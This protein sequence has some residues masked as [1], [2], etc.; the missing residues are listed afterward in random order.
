MKNN[1]GTV[2][3]TGTSPPIMIT[4]DH[5][6]SKQRI[7]RKRSREEQEPG[8][9]LRLDTPASSRR[10]SI[11][12]SDDNRP[13]ALTTPTLLDDDIPLDNAVSNTQLQNA[14]FL[15]NA[16]FDLDTTNN[17]EMEAWPYNRRRRTIQGYTST[18]ITIDSLFD[19]FP[20]TPSTPI[21]QL[22]RL[23]PA[24]GPTYGGIEVTLL[25]S[26]FYD[27]LTCLFG[28]HAV[29]TVFWNTSTL[30]CILPPAAQ[31]GPVVVSF[32]EHPLVLGQ[33]DVAIFT[34]LDTSD[35]AL[36]EL[37]LQVVGLK[38]TGKLHD[39]KNVAMGIV[40][41]GQNVQQDL[42]DALTANSTKYTLNLSLTNADGHT[43]LHLAVLLQ[44][45]TLVKALLRTQEDTSLINIQDKIQ[46]TAL[47]YACQRNLIDIARCLLQ[48]GANPSLENKWCM[49]FDE[50][51]LDL[52]DV[53][54]TKNGHIK[55]KPLSRRNS[56]VKS[57]MMHRFHSLSNTMTDEATA[58]AGAASR[59]TPS[60]ESDGLGLVK[61]KIDR[62]LYLFWLPVLIGKEVIIE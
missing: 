12:S 50:R 20:S 26:G 37:A 31:I 38:M 54:V 51:I 6:S 53:Y 17:D 29:N 41:G 52:L 5:K 40:Q 7:N 56:T 59:V 62:R 30:V 57:H 36:L 55:R 22:E 39:A 49:S 13:T 46:M 61:Q 47:H 2:V 33:H 35:Q 9:M 23:V 43:L 24:Q 58:G 27:G 42:I 48:A 3:A 28:E 11:Y 18:D 44:N 8:C 10:G 45:E 21:P 1:Q 34:Y 15:P 14:F 4:D 25:G 19:T 60:M 16:A 32:K